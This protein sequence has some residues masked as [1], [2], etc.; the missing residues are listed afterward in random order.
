[1]GK[2]I[3]ENWLGELFGFRQDSALLAV[4]FAERMSLPFQG[5]YAVL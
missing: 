3:F 1:M 2:E 5:D 4:R